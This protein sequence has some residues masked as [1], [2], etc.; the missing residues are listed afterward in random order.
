MPRT[1]Q[2]ILNF[3]YWCIAVAWAVGVALLLLT[4]LVIAWV[5]ITQW[6]QTLCVIPFMLFALYW[7]LRRVKRY[8]TAWAIVPLTVLRNHKNVFIER[9][10]MPKEKRKRG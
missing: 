6:E 3:L 4:P 10:I 2:L 1:E 9:S 8:Y 5:V 7:W